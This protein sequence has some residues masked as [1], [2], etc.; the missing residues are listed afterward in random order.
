MAVAADD[1]MVV[2]RNAEHATGGANVLGD[3]DILSA[4]GAV[5]AGMIVDQNDRGRPER[6]RTL[7]DP[8]TSARLTTSRV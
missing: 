3:R 5:A 4:G 2:Y 8:K 7:D 1:D 6:E